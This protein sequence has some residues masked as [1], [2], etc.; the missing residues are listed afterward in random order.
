MKFFC[1]THTINLQIVDLPR[2]AY[3]VM[4]PA[5]LQVIATFVVIVAVALLWGLS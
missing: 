1:N 4:P 2:N 3:K 5:K